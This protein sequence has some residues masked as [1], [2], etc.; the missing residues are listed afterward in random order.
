GFDG[1]GGVVVAAVEAPVDQRLGAAGQRLGSGGGGGGGGG[2]RAA[3]R[4]GGGGPAGRAG[5]GGGGGRESPSHWSGSR[6]SPKTSPG[7]N[8]TS[9]ARVPE[10]KAPPASHLSCWRPTGGGAGGEG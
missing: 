4:A 2:G 7:R 5:G 3:R 1:L 9:R 6:A 10:T 8:H